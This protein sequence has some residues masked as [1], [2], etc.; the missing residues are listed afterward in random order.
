MNTYLCVYIQIIFIKDFNEICHHRNWKICI[1]SL[2]FIF[3]WM[4]G[5]E[6][7][8]YE[9]DPH[10]EEDDEDAGYVDEDGLRVVFTVLLVG[11]DGFLEVAQEGGRGSQDQD[12]RA[13]VLVERK[14]QGPDVSGELGEQEGEEAKQP[15]TSKQRGGQYPHPAMQSV[16]V[17]LGGRLVL[18]VPGKVVAVEGRLQADH[19]Q[20]EGRHH[21]Q[22]VTDFKF[23]FVTV[24]LCWYD[25]IDQGT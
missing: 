10:H 14:Q 15:L 7:G 11:P 19:H 13:K 24:V 22:R 3:I 9:G 23:Q 4:F 6:F 5:A 21:C 20:Y 16:H 25:S 8:E 2:V 18:L 1:S 12:G 17:G